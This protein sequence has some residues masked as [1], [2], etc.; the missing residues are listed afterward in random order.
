MKKTCYSLFTLYFSILSV[1]VS[2]LSCKKNGVNNNSSTLP[3]HIDSINNAYLI[4]LDGSQDVVYTI[5]GGMVSAPLTTHFTYQSGEIVTRVGAYLNLVAGAPTFYD[6]LV[7]DTLI[8]NDSLIKI[9]TKTADPSLRPLP[10]N[11]RDLVFENG[12]L[13]QK[14]TATDTT[15]YYYSNNK[16]VKSINFTKTVETLFQFTYDSYN[17]LNQVN[18]SWY[19]IY[20]PSDSGFIRMNFSGFD[21]ASNSLSRFGLWDDLLYRSLSANNFTTVNFTTINYSNDDTEF[22]TFTVQLYYDASGN[23][24]LSRP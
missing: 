10:S 18:Q 5:F 7:Y 20:E 8:Y 11:E 9:I 22:G 21:H 3:Q 16:L 2:L 23:L 14:T 4:N 12:L 6:V 24:D 15:Y 17:N 13:Q 19:Y 1:F